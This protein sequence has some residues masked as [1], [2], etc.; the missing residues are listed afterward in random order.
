M[1]VAFALLAWLLLG[2]TLGPAAPDSS[3]DRVVIGAFNAENFVDVYDDPYSKD[4]VVKVKPRAEIEKLAAAIRAANADALAIEEVENEG[5]LR[6]MVKEFLPDM[7]YHHVIVNPTN[8]EYGTNLGIISRLPVISVTSHR[9]RDLYLPG[10]TRS[11]R[12][13]RDLLRVRLRATPTHALDLFIVHFHSRRD[14]GADTHAERWRLAEA[15]AARQIV[16]NA[17]AAEGDPW[18]ALVGDFNDTPGTPTLAQFLAPVDGAEALLTD[19]HAALP[20]DG[21]ITYLKAP[22]RSTI[23]YVLTSPALGRRLIPNSAR[24]VSDRSTLGGSDHAPVIA[25]FDVREAARK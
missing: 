22:Y 13:T 11:W 1:P 15:V 12:F 14:S 6:A 16:G 24:V 19:A 20:A 10:E 4:E 23:D 8:S 7:G 21:R 18:V 3:P 2:P 5:V 17:M 9:W 25:A